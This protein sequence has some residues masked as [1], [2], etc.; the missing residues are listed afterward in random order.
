VIVLKERFDARA[1]DY[2]V[3]E[4]TVETMP[5]DLFA[6]ADCDMA[7][8]HGTTDRAELL[9]VLKQRVREW[10]AS[11]GVVTYRHGRH[12]AKAKLGRLQADN[13]LQGFPKPIRAMLAAALY[14]DVDGVN[15]QPT[16]LLQLARKKK[17]AVHLPNLE[18]YVAER[19]TVLRLLQADLNLSKDEVK[20]AIIAILFG[21]REKYKHAFL[22]GF[23]EEM[24]KLRA[25]AWEEYGSL[26]ALAVAK[27]AE[28]LKR[29]KPSAGPNACLL[30]IVLQ[31]EE[32]RVLTALVEA[33]RR[34]DCSFHTLIHDGALLWQEDCPDLA[35]LRG[36]LLPRWEQAI[37]EKTG[38]AMS[39]AVK[40]MMQVR[41]P[42]K[43]EDAQEVDRCVQAQSL[44]QKKDCTDQGRCYNLPRMSIT[45]DIPSSSYCSV[46]HAL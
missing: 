20:Q 1:A 37:Q 45:Q 23:R 29:G 8:M 11:N 43:Q 27:H 33:A 18:R 5:A 41:V 30:A 22:T 17:W 24:E 2:I 25:C 13:G 21:G 39:L 10:A 28:K 15:A 36:T 7:K 3:D 12:W 19:D 14:W 44:L 32:C 26:H 31:T 42:S 46:F 6:R 9:H 40:P 38:Y 34:D 4:M 16:I 35:Y